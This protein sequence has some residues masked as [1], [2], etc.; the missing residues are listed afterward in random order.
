MKYVDKSGRVVLPK[1]WRKKNLKTGA[2]ILEVEDDKI[3]I[4]GYEPP[5]ILKYLNSVKVDIKSDLED[6]K[7]VKRELIEKQVR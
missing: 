3:I 2:V 7:A 4:K 5:N 6:W 1:E